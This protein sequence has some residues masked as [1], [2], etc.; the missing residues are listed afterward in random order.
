VHNYRDFSS[1]FGITASGTV[2]LKGVMGS[3]SSSYKEMNNT[4]VGSESLF[5]FKQI[6]R[7]IHEVELQLTWIDNDFNQK[8]KQKLD[9]QFVMDVAALPVPARVY[10]GSE[11]SAKGQDLPDDLKRIRG[12]Y[13]RLI[14][15]YGTHIAN[16]VTFG[17]QY[18]E[19]YEVRRSDYERTRG[20][21]M[22][23]KA[24][25]EKMSKSGGGGKGPG[26]SLEVNQSE[27]ETVG[28][29]AANTRRKVFVQGGNGE[30]DLSMWRSKVDDN[31]AP[32]EIEFMPLSEVLNERMFADDPDIVAKSKALEVITYHY[33]FN[34]APEPVEGADDFFRDLPPL[35]AP[36]TITVKNGGG[37]VMWFSVRY[38]HNGE[39]HDEESSNFPV[40]QSRD[41]RIP[42]G[43]TNITVKAAQTTGEIFT[44]T[45]PKVEDT[46]FKCWGT[47][48]STGW[49]K[50]E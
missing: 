3:L 23:F 8:Y 37:Y 45:V 7:K 42:A 34:E 22:A 4:K 19:R 29:K 48:F 31:M 33:L 5:M 38:Y 43:A 17:G 36:A 28:S 50:C 30:D 18:I 6:S 47:I 11:V 20:T 46:C 39:W 27:T 40:A 9:R 15:R 16:K 44:T 2:P 26:G 25:V 24:S 13:R 49:S 1:T 32:V 41:I 10:S 21:E 35:E 12:N 14:D